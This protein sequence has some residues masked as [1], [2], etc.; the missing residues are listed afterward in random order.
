MEERPGIVVLR[1]VEENDFSLY[2]A[3]YASPEVMRYTLIDACKSPEA[4]EPY[5]TRTLEDIR[6]PDRLLYEYTASLP[7]GEPVGM[8]NL[9]LLSTD[10]GNAEIGYMLLPPYWGKGYGTEIA[11]RLIR[12]GFAELG[13]RK[14]TACCN[15]NNLASEA[16]MKKCGMRRE[17]VFKCVRYKDGKWQDELRYAVTYEEWKGTPYGNAN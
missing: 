2:Y 3:M 16:V 9:K 14:V 13:L 12:I 6:K 4:Y 10:P 5:F 1:N 7:N 11:R 15:A 17:V 8:G